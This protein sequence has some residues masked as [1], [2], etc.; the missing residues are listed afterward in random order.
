[1]KRVAG[2]L[3][4]FA[5]LISCAQ[6]AKAPIHRVIGKDTIRTKVVLLENPELDSAYQK[7]AVRQVEAKLLNKP[8]T[9]VIKSRLTGGE[10]DLV[11]V[12]RKDVQRFGSVSAEKVVEIGKASG[13]DLL[14][15]VEPLRIDYAESSVRKEVEV[16]ISRKAK[17]LLSIKVYETA[18]GGILLAGV[19]EGKEEAKQCSKG[20][21]RTDKLPSKDRLVIKAL[22]KAG[23]KFS[24]EFWNNL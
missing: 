19:Y 23:E 10:V 8:V 17:V 15:V 4:F 1:M 20:V 5:F 9:L 3:L 12:T 18:K 7:L 14:V 22:K 11:L 16:C 2:L 21:E 24:K 6:T 13:V